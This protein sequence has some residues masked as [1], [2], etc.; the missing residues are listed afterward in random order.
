MTGPDE[1]PALTAAAAGLVPLGGPGWPCVC[2]P[3]PLAENPVCPGYPGLEAAACLACLQVARCHPVDPAAITHHPPLTPSPIHS[4]TPEHHPFFPPLPSA[5][6]PPPPPNSLTAIRFP[7]PDTIQHLHINPLHPHHT[8]ATV[9]GLAPPSR[10]R[11]STRQPTKAPAA[12]PAHDSAPPPQ[13]GS[14][15][16]RSAH[17]PSLRRT[18]PYLTILFHSSASPHLLENQ[19]TSHPAPS[20]TVQS[21]TGHR[22]LAPF[23]SSLFSLPRAAIP[24]SF[25]TPTE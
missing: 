25:V 24:S 9:S 14:R 11:P 2:V 17:V 8:P 15:L 21:A 18:D 6:R 7:P 13:P 4:S 22:L 10:L 12:H 20:A 19:L 16:D 23:P 3:C 5:C 1:K